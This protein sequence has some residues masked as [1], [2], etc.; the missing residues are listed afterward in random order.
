[1]LILRF[2]LMIMHKA[3]KVESL[4]QT[5]PKNCI[6]VPFLITNSQLTTKPYSFDIKCPCTLDSE[7][8]HFLIA[9]V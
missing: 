4:K 3:V 9:S 1:M 6:F 2:I 7:L 8:F 5:L